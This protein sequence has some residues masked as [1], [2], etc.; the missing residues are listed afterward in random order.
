MTSVADEVIADPVGLVVRL[1][2]GVDSHLDSAQV[3]EVVGTVVRERAGRRRLAQALHDDP[4]LLRTGRP[5]A[6]YCVAKLL[7]ALR[8]AGAQEIPRPRCSECGRECNW[9]GSRRGGQW[10]CS[11]CSDKPAVCAGCGEECRVVSRDRRG[12]PRCAHCPDNAGDPLAELVDLVTG[13]DSALD[14]EAVLTALGRATVRPAGQRR[15]AGAVLERPELL[16]GAGYNAP[17][18]A[19]LRFIDELVGAGAATIVR[20]ACPVC[21]EVK[22]LSKLLD[23]KRV[24]RNCFALQAA[25]A[26]IR[27]GAVREPAARDDSGQPLCPNCLIKDPANLEECQGCGRRLPVAVRSSDGPRCMNCRPR[28][29]TQ[30]GVCGRSAVCD[31]SRA[32]GRPWCLRCQQKWVTCSSCGDS[33]PLRGGSLDAPLCARCVNPDP[34][35]WGRCPVCETTWQLGPQPCQ[36]CALDQ[37]ARELLRGGCGAF[38]D[39]LAAFHQALVAVERPDS[40]LAWLARPKVRGLLE[41]IGQGTRPVTHELLDEL[42]AGK[43]LAHLRSVLVAT[44]ALP[45]RDERLV[46]LE[47]WIARTI[48][49]RGDLSER[50]I[51]HSYAVWHHLRRLRQ[52]LGEQHTT[53]LQD[54]NVRCHITA[55]ASFLDWLTAHDR[56]LA[57]CTQADLDT[58]IVGGHRY[59]DETGHFVRWAVT[60][61]RAHGLTFGATRWHGP[62]GPL[63]TEKRWADAR[64]LLH[65]D[66]LTIAD[67]VAG[68]LLL[69]YAQRIATITQLTVDDIHNNDN[70]VTITFGRVPVTLPEPLAA[71]ARELV[72]TRKANSI[73]AAPAGSSPWLFPGRRPGHPIG[74]DALG[75]RLQRIGLNP[76]QDR[77][78]ALFALATELPAAILARILGI[79][80]AVA[81]QWQQTSSG[82]WTAYAAE[83][84]RRGAG[85]SRDTKRH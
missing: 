32:T 40:A 3:R 49:S 54:L 67:R 62:A 35:F 81:V 46:A 53:R 10:A 69:L 39:G 41:Q 48:Q 61:K 28:T 71:L 83:V 43:T 80:I 82:D 1:V 14:A 17:A 68:L 79:H 52:R 72:A 63:D 12:E 66:T 55:A 8:A 20:P 15:L 56:T 19:V 57:D 76:R 2:C 25:V 27:C 65:D 26:C 51:L 33:G 77:S 7:M 29:V 73:I 31:T 70:A 24:C 9:V 47:R 74:D 6:P 78:T 44:G 22:A 11:P 21:G 4:S 45:P 37:R 16:T 64:R 85:A 75:N 59:R 60:Q 5:P 23:N 38:R 18:P 84:S 50:Q 30:C 34:Q 58:W 13:M 42:P 36:R